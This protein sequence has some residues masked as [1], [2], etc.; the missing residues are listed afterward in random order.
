MKLCLF[1]IFN[2]I[3]YFAFANGKSIQDEENFENG[4]L[5]LKKNFVEIIK[6]IVLKLTTKHV[7]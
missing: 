2:L 4:W 5:L 1:L 6:T 7:V 3:A